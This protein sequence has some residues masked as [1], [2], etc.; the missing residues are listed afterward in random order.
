LLNTIL[1]SLI[2]LVLVVILISVFSL[3]NGYLIELR[4][5]SEWLVFNFDE[6][7][8]LLQSLV[9]N[10]RNIVDK[11]ETISEFQQENLSKGEI[12]KANKTL[13]SIE[14]SLHPLDDTLSSVGRSLDVIVSHPA[15]T[16][17]PDD[18]F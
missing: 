13:I 7:K 11:I 6:G 14:C 8:R 18:P 4:K 10:T 2:L 16:H 17:H 5:H 15:F 12:D 9:D 3:F 1:L